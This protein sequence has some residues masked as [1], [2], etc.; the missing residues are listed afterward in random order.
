MA[1]DDTSPNTKVLLIAGLYTG[2]SNCDAANVLVKVG[3]A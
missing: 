3:W 1:F 2:L